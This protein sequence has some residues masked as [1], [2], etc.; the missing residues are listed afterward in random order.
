V[1]DFAAANIG[2]LVLYYLELGEPHEKALLSAVRALQ[3]CYEDMYCERVK[4]SKDKTWKPDGR[5]FWRSALTM[6]LIQGDQ[7][8]PVAT[9]GTT[10]TVC[11][12]VFAENKLY[13]AHVGDSRCVLGRQYWTSQDPP[14]EEIPMKIRMIGLPLTED[15]RPNHPRGRSF[16]EKH[17]G[18]VEFDG[19]HNFRVHSEKVKVPA[20][21]MSRALGDVLSK[22]FCGINSEPE[23]MTKTLN[24]KSRKKR[25]RFLLICSDGVWEHLTDAAVIDV[26]TSVGFHRTTPEKV[27]DALGNEA[28]KTWNEFGDTVD[29]ITSLCTFFS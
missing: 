4:F 9:S 28:W 23:I 17:G 18:L 1:S 8:I 24:M 21:N 27:L 6:G 15:H 26:V 19:F 2:M 13:V 5:S 12:E 10:A 16:I 22:F 25:D 7:V 3:N 29:D 11:L 14:V 20:L